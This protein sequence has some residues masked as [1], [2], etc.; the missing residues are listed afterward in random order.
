VDDRELRRGGLSYMID[1][2]RELKNEQAGIELF[3]IIG[4]DQVEIF[5]SWR[6]WRGIL[7]LA[8]PVVVGRPGHEA[9]GGPSELQARMLQ[10][11]LSPMTVSSSEVR[12]RLAQ[13]Q[14]VRELVPAAVLRY[15]EE[16][17]LYS[18][19]SSREGS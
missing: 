15:I 2:V 13:G 7:E 8:S 14:G 16:H 18:S 1:T 5:S 12:R 17:D 9:D 11:D 3:L 10:V 6:D 19:D 4:A